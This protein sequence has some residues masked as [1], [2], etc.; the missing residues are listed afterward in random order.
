VIVHHSVEIVIQEQFSGNL[1][2]QAITNGDFASGTT[3][4][5]PYY[6]TGAVADNEYTYTVTS[7]NSGARIDRADDDAIIGH[8]YYISGSLMPSYDNYA[9]V[10]YGGITVAQDP[11]V[12][13]VWNEI[14][15]VITASAT[16]RFRFY[17]RTD[18]EYSVSDT[19]KMKDM[20]KIDLTTAFGAGNEPTA[21]EVKSWIGT[22]WEGFKD[23]EQQEIYSVGKNLITTEPIDYEQGSL[24]SAGNFSVSTT[25]IRN[26]SFI[27]VK[28]NTEY[29]LSLS[30]ASLTYG[31]YI[32]EYDKNGNFTIRDGTVWGTGNDYNWT[33]N[34]ATVKIKIIIRFLSD[35]IIYPSEI[36]NV[37]PQLEVGTTATDYEEHKSSTI[38]LPTIGANLPNEVCDKIYQNGN[39]E[40]VRE[41]NVSD[42]YTLLSG[43]I[44]SLYT[45]PSNMDVVFCTPPIDNLTV[46]DDYSLQR[47]VGN[48]APRNNATYNTDAMH[49]THYS[50]SGNLYI[51]V[52]N[53]TYANLA[54]AQA[55]LAGT[56]I[57]YQLE[58]PV[59]TP[60]VGIGQL[61]AYEN[62]TIFTTPKG[63]ASKSISMDYATNIASQNEATAKGVVLGGEVPYCSIGSLSNQAVPNATTTVKEWDTIIHN[64]YNMF[65]ISSDDRI[66][67]VENGVYLI[68]A[69]IRMGS[70]STGYRQI[71]ITINGSAIS[72]N[73]ILS[74]GTSNDKLAIST[75]YKAEKN[76]YTTCTLYSTAGTSINAVSDS[77][78]TF[79]VVKVG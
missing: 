57:Y 19:F 14:Y 38:V 28:S 21:D 60:L 39:N 72:S 62:G 5:T 12:V 55:D 32:Y 53:G 76:D 34:E 56:K 26:F 16:S 47:T 78:T 64:D 13:D 79:R 68:I 66:T 9:R 71:A 17:H 54:A 73:R 61:L 10:T 35:A 3:G 31:F 36:E 24:D 42:E 18:T 2:Y 49:Y 43:D 30:G 29:M 23:T 46:A 40:W 1:L 8:K 59:T 25:R 67:F 69:N 44:D 51:A 27:D 70:N 7:V 63:I 65:D 6:G 15:G 52:P 33:T 50:G 37:K 41:Q 48:F 4:W 77:N 45:T 11:T 20:F 75:I 58:T 74:I 22:Y